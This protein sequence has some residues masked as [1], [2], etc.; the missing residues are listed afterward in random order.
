ME[1]QKM[2]LSTFLDIIKS[3]FDDIIG[4]HDY[5]IEV[6]IKAI[7][8]NRQFYYIDLVETKNGKIIDSTRAN[9]FN[10]EVM[11]SF[12]MQADISDSQE[13]VW[14]KLLI[15]VRP[16]FH[17]TYNFSLNILKIHADYFVGALEQKKKENIEELKKTGL[18]YN[19]QAQN[20]GFPEY[21]IA[22]ITGDKS[23]WF[24]DFETILKQSGFNYKITVFKSLV[25]G[26]KASWEVLTQLEKIELQADKFNLV[27]IMRGG[28]GSEWMNW[29]NDLKLSVQVCNFPIPVMSAVGHTVD[30]SILDMV[31]KYPCKTPSEA[32]QILIDIY[33]E[34]QDNLDSDFEYINN[35]VQDFSDKYKQELKFISKN[36]PLQVTNK[37]RIYKQ[38]LESFSI[39]RKI[40]YNL[41]IISNNLE[42]LHHNILANN[43]DKILSKWFNLVYDTKGKVAKDFQVWQEYIMKT[44]DNE[45]VINI[46]SKKSDDSDTLSLF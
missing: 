35:C 13:L 3:Q 20:I 40:S 11:R 17:K 23:E 33:Q 28:W 30:Q 18:F 31:S 36:L 29:A 43:P 1:T 42:I 10:S 21:N 38:R 8:R 26:E 25:H 15:N 46:K 44:K 2:S 14:K 45:Y 9:I 27:A 32:A 12:L 7:K 41:R 37:I 6:E 24:R 4:Y 39:D 16:T 5:L 34:F 22:V 19:N